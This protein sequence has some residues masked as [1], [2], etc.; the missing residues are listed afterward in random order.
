M[1]VNTS[2][3]DPVGLKKGKTFRLHYL[4]ICISRNIRILFNIHHLVII[5]TQTHQILPD[6]ESHTCAEKTHVVAKIAKTAGQG[7]TNTTSA[8]VI[9]RDPI[10]AVG[11]VVVVVAAAVVVVFLQP[12]MSRTP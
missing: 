2:Y 5:L 6:S 8:M 1:W 11:V 9:H 4:K 7:R 12:K 10:I 3:M